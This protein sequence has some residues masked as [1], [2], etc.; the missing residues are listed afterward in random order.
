MAEPQREDWQKERVSALARQ[1]AIAEIEP[2]LEPQAARVIGAFF[3]GAQRRGSEPEIPVQTGRRRILSHRT[4]V[5]WRILAIAVAPQI[6]L[7][8]LAQQTG[9]D[10]LDR[11]SEGF[12]AAALRAGLGGHLGL[13]RQ[14]DQLAGLGDLVQQRFLAKDVFSGL[15]ACHGQGRMP[16][17]TRGHEHP[18]DRFLRLQQL[19]VIVI[20]LD[21]AGQ[22]GAPICAARDAFPGRFQSGPIDVAQGR[23]IFSLLQN[24]LDQG[25]RATA[26]SD[27][28]DI[29]LVV[30]G[31]GI[32]PSRARREDQRNAENANPNCATT[33][34]KRPV[35]AASIRVASR[36]SDFLSW[37]A[38]GPAV[39]AIDPLAER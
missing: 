4:I 23:D 10:D 5:A 36:S 29:E 18:I 33:L 11:A 3:E 32:G 34:Q 15:H 9:P 13:R 26:G 16:A 27:D 30:G 25:R 37:H 31:C 6:D 21:F 12:S 7:T 39:E 19:A 2:V 24:G 20:D 8:D 14:F 17:G 35:E 1:H 28:R 38:V 22:V